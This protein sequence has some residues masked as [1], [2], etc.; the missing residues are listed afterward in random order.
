VKKNVFL[1]LALVG[2]LT[3]TYYFEEVGGI[4]KREAERISKALFQD[5]NLGEITAINFPFAKLIRRGEEF[6]TGEK[7]LPVDPDKL[8]EVLDIIAG[9]QSLS[10][11]KVDPGKVKRSH[12]FPSDTYKF[13]FEF[14]G[15]KLSYILG[16]KLD[17]SRD[18]YMEVISG[19]EKRVVVAR[20]T[21]AAM[22]IYD[23][24]KM[25]RD[26]GK[27]ERLKRII[28]FQEDAYYNLKPLKNFKGKALK[29]AVENKR[30]KAFSIDITKF[31]STPPVIGRLKYDEQ[32]ITKYLD[33]L[34]NFEGKRIHLKW[35]KTDLLDLVSKIEIT[36]DEGE[37]ITMSLYNQ[38]GNK[39]GHYLSVTGEKGLYQLAPGSLKN[40]Y[41]NV[42]DFWFKRAL[43][44]KKG[45]EIKLS[46]K[47]GNKISF[48]I[49]SGR[50]FRVE[51]N[52]G[53]EKLSQKSFH[54]LISL[55]IGQA[56]RVSKKED[57]PY[58]WGN[59][60]LKISLGNLALN[61]YQEND[62]LLLLSEKDQT[63][64][65]YK[66]GRDLPIGVQTSDYLS[67]E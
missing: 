61:I 23:P 42:Q 43:P 66:L 65:H 40:F 25:K 8:Q 3:F 10:V 35:K 45:E 56:K 9:V 48:K 12:F 31:S 47:D 63:V 34:K 33:W 24:K 27:F 60:L 44:A 50:P 64:F 19:G 22:G 17:Y 21:T 15:G 6:F 37:P 13:S 41:A 26:P 11:L 62:E 20:D 55:L 59:N 38:W 46:F 32:A 16:K 4:K 57:G 7:N 30:N 5:Q 54:K 67:H 51:S 1:F 36:R 49:I 14:R 28:L 58:S 2:L 52:S 39:K 53:K 29:I 18:F